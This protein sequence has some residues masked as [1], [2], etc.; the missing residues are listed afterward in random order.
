[1]KLNYLALSVLAVAFI[2]SMPQPAAA[3]YSGYYPT[4]TNPGIQPGYYPQNGYYPLTN[5]NL[6]SGQDTIRSAFFQRHA[7]ISAQINTAVSNGTLNSS[8]ASAYM[9]ELNAIA[10]QANALYS[11]GGF[12]SD[13]T[14]PLVARL[15]VL[16]Q[17]VSGSIAQTT[18]R[19]SPFRANAAAQRTYQRQLQLQQQRLRN[20]ALRNGNLWW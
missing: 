15:T 9:S 17:Q 19:F 6:L 4:Y 10:S 13:Q 7:E 12:T 3:Q 18:N 14:A 1:M 16:A 11:S 20:A 5:P 8:Q 2:S